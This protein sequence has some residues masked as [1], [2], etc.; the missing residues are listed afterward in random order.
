MPAAFALLLLILPNVGRP[1]F[2]ELAHLHGGGEA[3]P[4]DVGF[5]PVFLSLV[6]WRI[7]VKE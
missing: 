6:G 1:E 7:S 2:K 3:R 5:V 4:E